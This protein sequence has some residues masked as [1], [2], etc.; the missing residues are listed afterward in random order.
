M[1]KGRLTLGTY[2]VKSEQLRA[3]LVGVDTGAAGLWS[4]EDSLDELERLAET[5]D[6]EV[7]GRLSQKLA[8]PQNVTYLGSGKVG[9]LKELCRAQGADVVVFDDELSPRQESALTREF[10]DAVMIVDRTALILSIFADHATSREGKLQVELAQLEYELPRLRGK[11][12]HLTKEKLRGGT[13]SG[14]RFGAGESQLE[15]DRRIIRKRIT[16]LK[17]K[18]AAVERERLT[19]R[20][21][22]QASRIF[23]TVL[24]GYTNAGKSTLLNRLSAAE[25][26]VYDKLFATLDAT[27]RRIGFEDGHQATLTDTV[28]FINKLP[29]TLVASFK[30]TLDEVREADL[31]LHVVDAASP[32]ASAQIASVQEVLLELGAEKKPQLLV[33]NKSDELDTGEREAL[34]SRWPGSVAASALKGDGIDEL[35]RRLS[36]LS[37]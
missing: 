8:A 9:E 21:R 15:S 20:G 26:L 6:L 37:T 10:A 27:T 25:V 36:V 33:F 34:L 13:G 2:E 14:T 1:V 11:W 32:V 18:I 35:R 4:S 3:V 16:L 31:L 22:R 5:A 30:S 24:V 19:Q 29:H 17:G 12:S 7:A 23:R 28:G